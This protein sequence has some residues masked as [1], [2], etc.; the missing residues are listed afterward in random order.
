MPDF[1]STFVVGKHIHFVPQDQIRLISYAFWEDC[2]KPE[3]ARR[4]LDHVVTKCPDITG[5]L[6][7]LS[8][9]SSHG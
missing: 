9:R 1:D 5:K 7:I 8:W 6:I 3:T 2:S 4:C